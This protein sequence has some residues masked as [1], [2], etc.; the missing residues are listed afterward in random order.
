MTDPERRFT[1]RQMANELAR[2]DGKDP[3]VLYQRVRS[4]YQADLF[5]A[6]SKDANPTGAAY[7]PVEVMCRL[8]LEL[9]FADMLGVGSAALK[10]LDTFICFEEWDPLS[11]G[12]V[13]RNGIAAAIEGIRRGQDWV[14]VLRMMQNTETGEPWISGR[15]LQ[16]WRVEKHPGTEQWADPSTAEQWA[17]PTTPEFRRNRM[18]Q[19]PYELRAFIKVDATTLLKPLLLKAE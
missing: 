12:K 18:F 6:I 1:L 19:P 9:P 8:R 4:L 17:D 2:L 16:A 13:L 14:L 7:F 10:R 5:E 15:L 11:D 3:E